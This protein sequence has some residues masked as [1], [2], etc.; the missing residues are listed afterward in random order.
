VSDRP[1]DNE[2]D[3]PEPTGL[4]ATET[5]GPASAAST[6]QIG[7]YRLLDKLGEGGM[8]EVWLAEQKEPVK[9][10]VALKVIKQGMDTKQVVARFEAERQALAM[11]DHP[12]IAKVYDAGSTPRGRPY[13]AMEH[14][15]GV[16]ITEHCDRH[17]LTNR[18]RLDL[19]MQVCEGVQ[20][21]HHK[22][23]IHRDLK[24][25]N[26]LVSI[27]D[28]QPVPKI[29]DFGVAKAVSHKLTEQTM[30][31]Q[32]GVM[33]GTPAY[34]SPEQAEMTGQDIDT[35]TDVYALGMMLYELLVGALPFDQKEFREAGFEAIVRKIREDQ[36]PRP[37]TRLST[38]GEHSHQSARRRRTELPALRRELSGDLDWITL[39]ALEKDRTRR[40]SSPQDLAADIERYLTDRPVLASPPSAAY[41]AKKFVKR[42]TWGVAAAAIGLLVLIAFAG[43]MA[44]QTK[45][46]A[47]L[48]DVAEDERNQAEELQYGAD[49][50]LVATLWE[51][52]SSTAHSVQEILQVHVPAAGKPDRREFSWRY[53]W[54]LSRGAKEWWGPASSQVRRSP[55]GGHRIVTAE[56]RDLQVDLWQWTPGEPEPGHLGRLGLDAGPLSVFALSDDGAT[57]ASSNA[58]GAIQLFDAATARAGRRIHFPG[59]LREMVLSDDGVWLACIGDGQARVY[60]VA[61]GTQVW[62]LVDP[63][64]TRPIDLWLSRDGS[65]IVMADIPSNSRVSVATAAG[66]EVLRYHISTV[67]AV[68]AD[69]EGRR[70]YSGDSQGYVAV[71]DLATRELVGKPLELHRSFVTSLALSSDGKLLAAGASDG[72]IVVWDFELEVS[73]RRLAGHTAR[74]LSLSFSHDAQSLASTD[75]DGAVRV[76][77]LSRGAGETLEPAGADEKSA[78]T[79]TD[80]EVSPDGQL[81]AVARAN[82]ALQLW[83]LQTVELRRTL[84]S[85]VTH[86]AFSPDGRR[87]ALGLGAGRVEIC[88]LTTGQTLHTLEDKSPESDYT[89]GSVTFSPDGRYLALGHGWM[90][91]I[92]DN[93]NNRVELW[94]VKS[95]SLEASLPVSNSVNGL[96]FAPDGNSLAAV[97]RDGILRVASIPDLA[98]LR[99]IGRDDDLGTMFAAAYAPDGKLLATAG[100]M[101]GR[102][103]LW[104]TAT[105]EPVATLRG[106]ANIVMDLTFTPDSRTLV[107]GSWDGSAKLWDVA[108]RRQ[109][110]TLRGHTSWLWRVTVSPDGNTVV[111]G[112]RDGN[113]RLWRAA[114]AEEIDAALQERDRERAEAEARSAI[115]AHLRRLSESRSDDEP[116][117]TRCDVVAGL[118]IDRRGRRLS[119]A[120]LLYD[121]CRRPEAALAEFARVIEMA[122]AWAEAWNDRGHRLSQEKRCEEALIDHDRAVK[123]APYWGE[124]RARRAA[125][126]HC[127]GRSEESSQDFA[128]AGELGFVMS[129]PDLVQLYEAEGENDEVLPVYLEHLE[130]RRRALREADPL[131]LSFEAM[132]TMRYVLAGLD[133]DAEAVRSSLA[134]AHPRSPREE[135]DLRSVD[136]G[137]RVLFYV[138]NLTSHDITIY[139]LD[140]D[141]KRK[142][143]RSV[144]PG[145][146]GDVDTF[147]GRPWVVTGPADT[148]LAVYMPEPGASLALVR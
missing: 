134:V 102:V 113:V 29:I 66:F 23:V 88:E 81:L 20:H 94:D 98:E 6:E 52:E 27:R 109:T 79:I 103:T 127:L 70:G 119:R 30:H 37:S 106:H 65:T 93:Y 4:P 42:H 34:M 138:G 121:V 74:V 45:R 3:H 54:T 22:A 25:G 131:T 36:P 75:D 133:A 141:G 139:W 46:I 117:E 99:V 136:G 7:P 124:A 8:G 115:D 16:P 143:A 140:H 112:G 14:V 72:S 11:M 125:A 2:D 91:V 92:T 57:A 60:E 128:R 68:V 90:G 50:Q 120:R 78:R 49:M 123:L 87:I 10:K 63:R 56:L 129:E 43:T 97:S 67:S 15:Q 83:D 107:T 41:R 13:F 1:H 55:E 76:W 38:L 26:V 95:G 86:V 58:E 105:Y 24:P 39:K 85:G 122:P 104:D 110:R 40:Y 69:Q 33:I 47:G 101:D 9:R 64:F 61:T 31:T 135:P 71:W 130:I 62:S 77:D 100:Q 73:R 114:S 32:L 5:G 137:A 53:Q 142:R 89:L 59:R 145:E 144:K 146:V 116:R 82:R 18:E 147:A 21:A 48:R 12:A 80:L 35:R 17:K 19:F 126:L 51:S 132:L 84:G 111:S 118:D 44:V 28:G 96:S 108:S 148:T